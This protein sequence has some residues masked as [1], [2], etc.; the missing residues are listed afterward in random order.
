MRKP[1]FGLELHVFVE[2]VEGDGQV[3]RFEVHFA[4]GP[5][6]DELPVAVDVAPREL[7]GS[8]FRYAA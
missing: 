1:T 2:F 3:E 8:F 4:V 6:F 5:I 7:G